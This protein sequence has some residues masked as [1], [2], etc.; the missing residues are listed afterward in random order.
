MPFQSAHTASLINQTLRSSSAISYP[1]PSNHA[2]SPLRKPHK[3]WPKLKAQQSPSLP[4]HSTTIAAFRNTVT[5]SAE[6]QTSHFF[7]TMTHW[8][9]IHF[10]ICYLVAMLLVG[11]MLSNAAYGREK[12]LR[13]RQRRIGIGEI[14][15]KPE[16]EESRHEEPR[17]NNRKGLCDQ[18]IRPQRLL[19]SHVTEK[20]C[21]CRV[22]YSH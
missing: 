3:E 6:I 20:Q 11:C 4:F 19:C 10:A 15:E 17:T 22:L 18:S 21:F 2:Q 14:E 7:T 16:T 1:S 9:A 13:I 12:S 8:H 5:S